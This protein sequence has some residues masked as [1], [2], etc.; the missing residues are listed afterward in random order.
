MRVVFVVTF[1]FL[2]IAADTTPWE[3]DGLRAGDR[4]AVAYRTKYDEKKSLDGSLSDLKQAIYLSNRKGQMAASSEISAIREAALVRKLLEDSSASSPLPTA[5]PTQL[6]T[7]QPTS[8]PTPQ[9]A[10]ERI[11]TPPKS[12]SV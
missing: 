5:Q 11:H 4:P 2:S 10:G 12:T 7:S 8:L 3:A 6:P 1:T 9:S